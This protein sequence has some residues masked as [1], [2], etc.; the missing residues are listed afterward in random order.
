MTEQTIEDLQNE[1]LGLKEQ[2]ETMNTT[3]QSLNEDKTKITSERDEARKLNA[4][5]MRMGVSKETEIMENNGEEPETI[6]QFIDSFLLPA[7]EAMLKA[8]G[9]KEE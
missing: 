7:K 3:I 6:E 5:L 2:L 8:Y 9:V 1:I 4:K